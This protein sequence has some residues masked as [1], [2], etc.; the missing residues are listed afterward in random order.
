MET[1]EQLNQSFEERVR[2]LQ[3]RAQAVGGWKE[4]QQARTPSRLMEPPIMAMERFSNVGLLG[5]PHLIRKYVAPETMNEL[6]AETIPGKIAAGIGTLA[7]FGVGAPGVTLGAISKAPWLRFGVPAGKSIVPLMQAGKKMQVAKYLGGAALKGGLG[8]TAIET[9][10]ILLDPE[11]DWD[12]KAKALGSTFALGALFGIAGGAF[13]GRRTRKKL[14]MSTQQK[15]KEFAELHKLNPAETKTMMKYNKDLMKITLDYT[16]P[17]DV[18]LNKQRMLLARFGRTAAYEKTIGVSKEYDALKKALKKATD[19]Q[20]Q[21]RALANQTKLS[22]LHMA[23]DAFEEKADKIAKE[24]GLIYHG[25]DDMGLTHFSPGNQYGKVFSGAS[26]AVEQKELSAL[27]ISIAK[28]VVRNALDRKA[29]E[30]GG[31]IVKN[32]KSRIGTDLAKAGNKQ[33]TAVGQGLMEEM[34]VPY[35]TAQKTLFEMRPKSVSRGGFHRA[36]SKGGHRIVIYRRGP[37]LRYRNVPQPSGIHDYSQEELSDIMEHEIMHIIKPAYYKSGAVRRTVHS[38]EFFKGVT[39]HL[40]KVLERRLEFVLTGQRSTGASDINAKKA[41]AMFNKMFRV[42]ERWVSTEE[43]KGMVAMGDEQAR[44]AWTAAFPGKPSIEAGVQPIRADACPVAL[45]ISKL[46]EYSKAAPNKMTKEQ[47]ALLRILRKELG[48]NKSQYRAFLKKVGKKY[49]IKGKIKTFEDAEL[50][51]YEVEKEI[52]ELTQLTPELSLGDFAEEMS[53]VYGKDGH[54]LMLQQMHHVVGMP[55]GLKYQYQYNQGQRFLDMYAKQA[56]KIFKGMNRG[57]REVLSGLIETPENIDVILPAS[58]RDIL[59]GKVRQLRSIYNFLYRHSQAHG[60]NYP[61]KVN[62]GA[63]IFRDKIHRS[64][65]SL[66]PDSLP[67]EIKAFYEKHASKE[68]DRVLHLTD[69]ADILRARVLAQHRKTYTEPVLRFAR[70][71]YPKLPENRR[72]VMMDWARHSLLGMPTKFEA[73]VDNEINALGKAILGRPLRNPRMYRT[74]RQNFM[75]LYYAGKLGIRPYPIVRNLT[76]RGLT[77]IHE[78]ATNAMLGEYALK[79]QNGTGELGSSVRHA[80]GK[81]VILKNRGKFS[82]AG[83]D[84]TGMS[85]SKIIRGI[86]K[87]AMWGYRASDVSNCQHA[88]LTAFIKSSR[89]SFPELSWQEAVKKTLGDNAGLKKAIVAGERCIAETQWW[90]GWGTPQLMKRYKVA[91][92]FTTW[93]VNYWMQIGKYAQSDQAV[94]RLAKVGTLGA[95]IGLLYER[96][97]DYSSVGFTIHWRPTKDFPFVEFDLTRGTFG[98]SGPTPAVPQ[99]LKAGGHTLDVWGGMSSGS[100]YQTRGGLVG[101]SYETASAVRPSLWGDITKAT[102]IISS[103]EPR[104]KV[105]EIFVKSS[106]RADERRFRQMDIE[107]KI[108]YR[109]KYP[110]RFKQFDKSIQRAFWNQVYKKRSPSKGLGEALIEPWKRTFKLRKGRKE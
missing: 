83:L 96:G 20:S 5:L 107:S 101:L 41:T 58:R 71:M 94:A 99:A 47:R 27:P 85:G 30:F 45:H 109:E 70:V 52:K 86:S 72:A 1:T 10:Q 6:E 40:D 75:Q 68:L 21:I 35:Q 106:V 49:D 105:S 39:D 7:G 25:V 110:E 73:Y 53:R 65:F 17:Q 33:I 95:F 104:Y 2:M 76:Q 92:T 69:A 89:T 66:D 18:V 24:F 61:K 98:V 23:D 13:G 103:R 100:R 44:Q 29:K 15:A 22:A 64:K 19:Q 67:S 82:A 32:W 91:S 16:L 62:Y 46:I 28:T 8:Y 93:P 12:D 14:F 87:T 81:S 102:D 36:S 31:Q 57:D 63:H 77:I 38:P 51:Q 54:L 37:K 9:P 26:F 79:F 88:Y 34:G 3:A 42:K 74:L 80:L 55:L 60:H 56:G 50:L 78:D 97:I 11:H 4:A 43:Y 48:M 84:L 108:G 59:R 90:Y